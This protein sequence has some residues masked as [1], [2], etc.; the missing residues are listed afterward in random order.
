MRE[1][2]FDLIRLFAALQVLMA[3]SAGHLSVDVAS[4]YPFYS[5][6]VLMSYAPGVPVFFVISGFLIPM[7]WDRAPSF[8]QYVWNRALRIYPGLWACLI[9]SIAII[10][11]SGVMP[12]SIFNFV[13]WL[14]AQITFLQFYD[15]DFLRGFGVGVI[16][17]SLW[18]IPVMLQFYL[19][20]PI[21]A[22]AAK[23]NKFSW[24]VF[25]VI[26]LAV[27]IFLRNYMNG[28]SSI[29]AKI[30]H[31]S[32]FPYLFLFLSGFIFRKIYEKY[33]YIFSGKALLW[34]SIYIIWVLIENHF[35]IKGSSGNNLNIISIIILSAVITSVAFT[36]THLSGL[37]L[38]GNDLSYGLYI[39]HMPIVNLLIFHQLVGL[40]GFLLTIIATFFMAIISYRFIEKPALGI[41]KYSLRWVNHT[42]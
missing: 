31:V 21:L 23:R 11:V 9:F 30:I 8:Q 6:M 13:S 33:P 15:P 40:F 20:F 37:I 14:L 5:L 29:F 26:A 41:K 12:D 27:M 3:H 28:N 32:I 10:F 16:N 7:S 36:Y 17:G 35:E 24:I 34:C 18:V 22:L 38:K 2:N 42:R 39:Y 4:F 1:N 25:L 19:L